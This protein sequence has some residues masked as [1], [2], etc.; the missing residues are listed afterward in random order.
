M[1]IQNYR[2][3]GTRDIAEGITTRTSIKM[4]P[5]TLHNNARMKLAALNFAKSLSDLSAFRGWRLEQ[6][7]GNRVGQYSIRINDQ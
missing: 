5:R 6:L 2:N 4:L 7:K 3:S 1:P